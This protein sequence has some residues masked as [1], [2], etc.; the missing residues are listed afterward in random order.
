MCLSS[1]IIDSGIMFSIEFMKIIFDSFTSK[2]MESWFSTNYV[3]C[4]VQ[5]STKFIEKTIPF[6]FGFL[7]VDEFTHRYIQAYYI[8]IHFL[9]LFNLEQR[10]QA[11][12]ILVNF[13]PFLYLGLYP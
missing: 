8:S 3:S 7:L 12:S 9:S 10:K 6:E 13:R 1:N 5:F 11:R 4:D 2:L